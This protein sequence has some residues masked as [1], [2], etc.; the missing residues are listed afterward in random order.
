MKEVQEYLIS[1]QHTDAEHSDQWARFQQLYDKRLWHEL[2]VELTSFLRE[3]FFKQ[4]A[5]LVEIYEKFISDF[6]HRLN[7]L[8]LTEIVLVISQELTDPEDKLKLFEKTKERAK[9]SIEATILLMT[10]MGIVKLE[11]GKLDQVKAII[12]EAQTKLDTIDGVTTVH[13]R[14]YDLSSTYFMKMGSFNKYYRD[15]LRYLGCMDLSLLSKSELKHRAFS[16]VLAALLGN[17]VYNFGELLAHDV[18]KA[19]E[20]TD[21]HW[22]IDLLLAFNTGNI[23]K[24]RQL[25]SKWKTQNDLASNEE[26]LA[27]KITL[28]AVMELS[29]K[30]PSTERTIP[31]KVISEATMVPVSG[32]EVLVM[33]A[34]SLGLI[35]GSIDEVNKVVHITWVQPRVLDIS[36]ISN[37]NVLLGNWCQKVKSS[38]R[39]VE[40]QVPELL[41]SS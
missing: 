1:K 40:D 6:E 38:A 7:P 25:E 21:E 19:L 17:E 32:V 26:N 31:F 8:S 33:K 22:L 2:T 15:A 10:A 36:Q 12:Q 20:G 24:F 18:L 11:S 29:F 30:R 27:E 9:N 28:L 37:M 23:E 3:D 13:G 16:L 39:M 4:N 5:G 34:L 35:K 41:V 14:F